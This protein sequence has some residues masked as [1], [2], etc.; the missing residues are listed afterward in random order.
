MP[1]TY[2]TL[3]TETG[4]QRINAALANGETHIPLNL[5]HLAVGD[6]EKVAD[7][8]VPPNKTFTELENEKLRVELSG[9]SIHEKNSSWL[10]IEASLPAESGGYTIR[11]VGIFSEGDLI[12][13]A[14]Y[15]D[16]KKPAVSSGSWIK[17]IIRI[18]TELTNVEAVSLNND[19]NLSYVSEEELSAATDHLKNK[20]IWQIKTYGND[21]DVLTKGAYNCDV[22]TGFK[23]FL[24]ANPA[25]DDVVK[26]YIL[27]GAN[28]L[29]V[30][31]NGNLIDTGAAIIMSEGGNYAG[32]LTFDGVKW[33]VSE[34]AGT[35]APLSS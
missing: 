17:T 2:Y 8:I 27:K 28:N 18:V 5:T 23:M 4:L 31:G 16:T 20:D 29:M 3:T 12:F 33:A 34:L 24:P 6:S 10:N 26:F 25:V 15:P 11:E 13:V 19:P 7:V 22:T 32:T 9:V 14:R 35:L 30:D 21:Q 1:I